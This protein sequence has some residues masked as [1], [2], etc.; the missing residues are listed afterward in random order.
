M[1][2]L[3]RNVIKPSLEEVDDRAGFVVNIENVRGMKVT[4]LK[5]RLK[6]K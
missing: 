3:T 5:Y 1:R 2:E 4:D 6:V